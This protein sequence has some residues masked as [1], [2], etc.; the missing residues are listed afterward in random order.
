MKKIYFIF[1]AVFLAG[2]ALGQ[3]PVSLAV[4]DI[5]HATEA[6][7]LTGYLAGRLDAAYQHRIMEQNIEK[8]VQPFLTRTETSCW[9]TEFWGKWFTSAVL[10]YRYKP[11]PAL[12]AILDK[13]VTD[14]VQTQDA[15]GYI[16]NYAPGKH[17]Q[18][19]DIW[20][21]KYCMLGLISYYD[22]TKNK[23]ALDAAGR[24]ADHLIKELDDTKYTDSKNG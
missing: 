13:S 24:V 5:L 19:W 17:L 15:D 20:G 18:Q 22:L 12:K 16:G 1:F 23:T 9:Q 10:A 21:R 3:Q 7:Q 6:P 8:L 11:S 14:L 2:G 4:A